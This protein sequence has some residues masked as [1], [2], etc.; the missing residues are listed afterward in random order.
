MDDECG[1][2]IQLLLKIRF[3]L[4]HVLA[5]VFLTRTTV[6]IDPIFLVTRFTVRVKIGG[7]CNQGSPQEHV[8]Q[9]K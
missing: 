8:D 3:D 7:F 4:M 6:C 5:N 1:V 9:D 2:Q